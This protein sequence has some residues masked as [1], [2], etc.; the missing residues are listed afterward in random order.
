MSAAVLTHIFHQG[1]ISVNQRYV[2]NEISYDSDNAHIA[3]N[4]GAIAALVI[5]GKICGLT[6]FRGR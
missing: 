4:R 6:L 5:P 1:A 2:K 3:M